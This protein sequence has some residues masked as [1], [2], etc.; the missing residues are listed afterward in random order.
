MNVFVDTSAFL[1]VLAADDAHHAQ[2]RKVW[3]DLVIQGETL[4]CSNYVL[5]ESFALAQNRLGMAAVSA[6]QNDVLP[7]M[8]VEWV[9]KVTHRAGVSALIT[10]GRRSF[11]LVDCTSFEIMRH[12]G[13]QRAFAFD[14]HFSDQGFECLP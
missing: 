7:M 9:D 4:V 2:A 12:L 5:V 8:N 10:A 1:A 11:S 13:I 14:R 6:F 3:Q